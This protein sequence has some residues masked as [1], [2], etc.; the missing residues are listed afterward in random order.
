[1]TSEAPKDKS[2]CLITEYIKSNASAMKRT[3]SMLS[4]PEHVQDQKKL[5]IEEKSTDNCITGDPTTSTMETVL[6]PILSEIKLLRES[7]HTDYSKLHSDCARL[8][9]VITKESIDVEIS[10][11]NN[12]T[13]N[14]Q[15]ILEIAAENMELKKENTQLKE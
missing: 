5:N 9:E 4:L 6:A 7:V 3:S 2:M 12:I 11:S 14:T 8:E 10:L 13:N 15:K 1:M